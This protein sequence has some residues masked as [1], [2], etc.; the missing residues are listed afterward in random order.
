MLKNVRPKSLL[1]LLYMNIYRLYCIA[2]SSDLVSYRA[3]FASLLL[4]YTIYSCK[5][6]YIL[7]YYYCQTLPVGVL[8]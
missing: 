8:E 5:N 4:Y 3:L 1:A 7:H 6:V 2:K